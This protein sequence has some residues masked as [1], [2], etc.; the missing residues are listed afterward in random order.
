[1]PV[2]LPENVVWRDQL[3]CGRFDRTDI[4]LGEDLRRVELLL[5]EVEGVFFERLE[6]YLA[7]NK[8]RVVKNGG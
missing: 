3:S 8:I 7:D 4:K 5:N 1:M 6:K 2:N